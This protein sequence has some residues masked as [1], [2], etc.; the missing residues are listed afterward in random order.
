MYYFTMPLVIAAVILV[1]TIKVDSRQKTL[2]E[3]TGE[4]VE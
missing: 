3:V 4:P 2:E 1:L